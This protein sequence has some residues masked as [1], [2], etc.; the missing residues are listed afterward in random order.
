MLLPLGHFPPSLPA[1]CP[2]P[3][4]RLALSL[5]RAPPLGPCRPWAGFSQS[6]CGW[7][8]I[9]SPHLPGWTMGIWGCIPLMAPGPGTQ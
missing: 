6:V 2:P 3:G 8:V 7:A 5:G 1:W 9:P 4:L